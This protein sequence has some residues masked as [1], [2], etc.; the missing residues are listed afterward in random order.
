MGLVDDGAVA[1]IGNHDH[2]IS[3]P[4]ESM[5]AVATA[6]IIGAIVFVQQGGRDGGAVQQLLGQDHRILNSGYHPKE[7]IR[8]LW[9]TIRRCRASPARDRFRKASRAEAFPSPPV[10]PARKD[11]L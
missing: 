9:T 5:N 1:V 6:A 10:E 7:F 3:T 2:A 11:S 8:G 4:T